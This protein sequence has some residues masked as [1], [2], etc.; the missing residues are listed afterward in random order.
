MALV[1][2]VGNPIKFD[3]N[4]SDVRRGRFARVCVEIDLNK[5]VIGKVWL[6]GHWYCVEYEGLHRI[7][8]TCGCYEH[9]TRNCKKKNGED[10]KVYTATNVQTTPSAPPVAATAAKE[11]TSVQIISGKVKEQLQPQSVEVNDKVVN[12]ENQ[13]Q[14]HGDRM[15][16]KK[17]KKMEFS[18]GQ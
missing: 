8:T 18:V 1:V 2:A 17:K 3:S 4:T 16:V 10:D 6:H 12:A 5:S 14:L 9:F 15:I 7:C 13:E 11:A